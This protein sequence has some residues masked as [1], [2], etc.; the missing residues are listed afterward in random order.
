MTAGKVEIAL[1]HM[2]S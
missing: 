2:H 1:F